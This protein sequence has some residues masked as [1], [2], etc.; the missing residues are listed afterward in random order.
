MKRYFYL[1]LVLILPSAAMTQPQFRSGIFLHHSTGGYIWGPNGSSTSIPN[2]IALYNA[3]HGYTGSNAVSMT[4]Q[5]FPGAPLSNDN[6]W[7]RWHRIFD[8]VDPY[9]NLAPILAANKIVVV[10]SCYPS[11]AMTGMG[12]P[13]DTNFYTRKTM[14]NHKWHMRHIVRDMASHPENFFGL[15]TNAP[16]VAGATNPNAALLAKRFTTWMKDTLAQG[17]DPEFGAFPPNVY[18]FHYFQ[19]LADEN[20]YERAEYAVSNTDSHPNSAATLLVAPQF[21]NEIF[22]AA[23]AYE[24]GNQTKILNVNVLFEGLYI[25]NGLMKQVLDADGPRYSEGIA[26]VIDIELHS[27]TDYN[28]TEFAV[29]DAELLTIGLASIEVPSTLSGSYYITIKHRNSIETA[30]AVP[31]SFAASEIN[32]SFDQPASAF[33]NNLLT[34]PDGWA[35]IYSSDVDQNGIVDTADFTPVDNLSSEYSMGYYP[36]DVNGDGFVD[37]ADLSFMDNNQINFVGA[38]LPF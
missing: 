13:A 29:Q 6:E 32:Y 28:V 35:V 14:Y 1:L 37:T 25:G 21:V 34:V 20:G 15:W 4:E 19:K 16:L 26:D 5:W 23:I 7:E 22:N 8:G 11:S 36:E 27:A 33:G 9:A 30:S 17:L 10:K 18:V 12:S 31:V 3:A 24:Q 38:I 2:E